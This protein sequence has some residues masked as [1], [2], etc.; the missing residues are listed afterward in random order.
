MRPLNYFVPE[1]INLYE[2][3]NTSYPIQSSER[4]GR[5]INNTCLLARVEAGDSGA[6]QDT[7]AASYYCAVH[8]PSDDTSSRI[9]CSLRLSQV[10]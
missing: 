10:T 6:P 9:S 2:Q 4:K 5:Q 7:S 3:P 8:T 1:R